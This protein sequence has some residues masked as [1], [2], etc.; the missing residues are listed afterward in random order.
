MESNRLNTLRIVAL[1]T[2]ATISFMIFTFFPALRIIVFCIGAAFIGISY[3]S[4]K[5]QHILISLIFYTLIVFIFDGEQIALVQI[6]T[7]ILPSI[8]LGYF[9]K[10]NKYKEIDY[11]IPT[12]L[13]AI[14]MMYFFKSNVQPSDWEN[15]EKYL[16]L[17]IKSMPDSGAVLTESYISD[18]IKTIKDLMPAIIVIF[19]MT[20]NI[21]SKYVA[22]YIIRSF[23]PDNIEIPKFKQF[24][25]PRELG[26]L[27]VTAYVIVNVLSF[28]KIIT[29]TA[30]QS[31]IT[32]I[33][34]VLSF[35]LAFQGLAVLIFFAAN[36][37]F[38][39]FR[40]IILM[41]SYIMFLF[42]NPPLVIIALL[43]IFLDVRKL[44][45]RRSK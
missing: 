32:N 38:K 13:T 40:F 7:L 11:I 25:V 27:F 23:Q 26:L 19:A 39:I 1:T 37:R 41:I 3:L 8:I 9:L 14:S 36:I 33:M 6:T 44:G 29:D 31:V 42:I 5:P 22:T 35:A 43:D 15:I 21:F 24:Y 45:F 4:Q 2:L 28:T 34:Y 16:K 30:A 17:S 12:M 10:N 20:Y 18:M